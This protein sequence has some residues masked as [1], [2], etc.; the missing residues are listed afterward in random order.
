[1]KPMTST[2]AA[3]IRAELGLT[4]LFTANVA[5]IG[6]ITEPLDS[7]SMIDIA[8][9]LTARAV[10]AIHAAKPVARKPRG[11]IEQRIAE[12]WLFAGAPGMQSSSLPNHRA[13]LAEI[14]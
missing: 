12:R 2:Q 5:Y 13:E 1:M 8:N 6:T 11:T 4:I 10:E 3:A 14:V 7:R 9:R